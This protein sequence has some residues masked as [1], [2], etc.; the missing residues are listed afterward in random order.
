MKI[1]PARLGAVAG[2]KPQGRCHSGTRDSVHFAA[3]MLFTGTQG[4]DRSS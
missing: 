4:E 3:T 1:T 2:E